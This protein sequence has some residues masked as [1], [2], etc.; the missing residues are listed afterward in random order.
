MMLKFRHRAHYPK[1]KKKIGIEH[2]TQSFNHV[3]S[4]EKFEANERENR[5]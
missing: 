2:C 4:G 3:V 5:S 1:K